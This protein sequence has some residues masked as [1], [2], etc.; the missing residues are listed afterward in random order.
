MERICSV[1]KERPVR[2]SGKRPQSYCVTCNREYAKKHYH[3]N[4]GAFKNKWNNRNI[5]LD[6]LVYSRKKVP[7]KDCGELYPHYVMDF[8]HRDPSEKSYTINE[9][10]RRRMAFTDILAE[11]AKCDVVCSNC[12]RERTHKQYTS[13]YS[14]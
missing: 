10:R 12:H 13:R 9:M 4:K 6:E 7:C 2:I 14:G 1:C 11:I 8:D 3:L 5:D